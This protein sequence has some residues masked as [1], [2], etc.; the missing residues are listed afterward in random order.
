MFEFTVIVA[1]VLL[2][3]AHKYGILVL[4]AMGMEPLLQHISLLLKFRPCFQERIV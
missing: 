1:T 4:K 2:F 3:S